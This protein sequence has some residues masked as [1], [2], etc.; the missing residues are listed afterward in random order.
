MENIE[1]R[2]YMV[3]NEK[4]VI[5]TETTESTIV[6]TCSHLSTFIMINGNCIFSRFDQILD[7]VIPNR[8]R[9]HW[10]E[11]FYK[12]HVPVRPYTASTYFVF[13][14]SFVL[15]ISKVLGINICYHGCSVIHRFCL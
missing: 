14:F 11:V 12:V 4:V 10:E 8:T 13:R 7:Q 6:I 2:I 9:I 15:W 3:Y 5:Q 1:K